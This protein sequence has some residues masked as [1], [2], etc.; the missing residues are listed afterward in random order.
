MKKIILLLAL[1]LCF[2]NG[3]SQKKKSTKKA[4][5]PASVLAKMNELTAQ[6]TP[7]KDRF[8]VLFGKDTLFTRKIDL[9]GNNKPTTK[10][11]NIPT[12]CTI[13]PVVVKGTPLYCI[14][15]S[16]NN[17]NEVTE[18]KEDRTKVYSEIWNPVTKT[19]VLANVQTTTKITE[20]LWLDKGKN[21]SQTS[22]KLRRE[23][24]EFSMNKEGDVVLKNKTQ[25]NKMVYNP[26]TNVYEDVKSSSPTA[27]TKKK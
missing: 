3:Y 23:G 19:Q 12:T 25:E 17:I 1:S 22:E 8:E 27:K 14:T 4:G 6:L 11:N 24:F 5:T 15:W 21:A 13:T 7:K 26:T 9:S 18:K 20:I 16:D 2:T 10:N